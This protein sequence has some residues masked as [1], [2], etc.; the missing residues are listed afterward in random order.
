MFDHRES[1]LASLAIIAALVLLFLLTLGLSG[2]IRCPLCHVKVF[3][4]TG[5][6]MNSRHRKTLLGSPRLYIA[7]RVTFTKHYR[8]PYCGEPCQT[9]RARRP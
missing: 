8:C 5:A 4:R 6:T 2:N 9:S 3:R 1:L 7:T